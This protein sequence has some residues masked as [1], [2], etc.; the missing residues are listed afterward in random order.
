MKATNQWLKQYIEKTYKVN[1]ITISDCSDKNQVFDIYCSDKSFNISVEVKERFFNDNNSR[2]MR[3]DDILIELIQ[4]WYS[5]GTSV[6][7]QSINNITTGGKINTSM[8]W[9]YKCNAGRLFYLRYYNDM[10]YDIID[11]DF[12]LFK[13]WLLDNMDRFEL[14][15]CGK[16]TQ[17]VNLVV[18]IS[19]IPI[20]ILNYNLG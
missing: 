20:T 12:R 8:G 5:F 3:K 14:Q 13:S 19:D 4:H 18:P 1:N 6:D 17:T 16:T 11:I 15:W 9:F 2:Y 10:F 7:N